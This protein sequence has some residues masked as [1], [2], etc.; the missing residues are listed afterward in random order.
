LSVRS[1]VG[2][3]TSF[4]VRLPISNESSEVAAA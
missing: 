1:T 3:G 2:S 4:T